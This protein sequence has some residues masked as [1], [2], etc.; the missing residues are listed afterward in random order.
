MAGGHHRAHPL[1]AHQFPQQPH[2]PNLHPGGAREAGGHP[3]Q[4]SARTGPA[5]PAHLRRALPVSGLRRNATV[6]AIFPVYEHSVVVSSFSKNLALAGE[7]VGY[8]AVNPAMPEA[9]AH[10]ISGSLI[11][12]NRILGFVNAPAVGQKLLA[13]ALGHEV[14]ASDLRQPPRRHGRGPARGRVLPSPCR[15]GPFTSFRAFPRAGTTAA[16]VNELMQEQILA[17]PGSGFGYPGLFPPGLLRGRGHHPRRGSRI[18]AGLRRRPWASRG[19]LPSGRTF[20]TFRTPR[21]RMVCG[22]CLSPYLTVH[23]T[24]LCNPSSF[25]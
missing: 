3:A 16:F 21:T 10:L 11:L 20:A 4:A 24:C 23:G 18:R 5:H 12:T 25:P 6:P 15:R 19:R 14:D 2:G 1:R 8:V 22:A 9:G 7:R 17:V 13:R